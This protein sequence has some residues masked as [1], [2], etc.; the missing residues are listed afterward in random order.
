M[1]TTDKIIEYLK[2]KITDVKLGYYKPRQPMNSF[3]R[4][5]VKHILIEIDNEWYI[6]DTYVKDRFG[7]C[8]GDV[9]QY[10]FSLC[11]EKHNLVYDKS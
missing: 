8:N 4:S 1:I 3:N 9:S 10:F 2:S 6:L 7:I 11:K 5:F